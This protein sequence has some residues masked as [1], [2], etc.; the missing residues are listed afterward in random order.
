MDDYAGGAHLATGTDE[1]SAEERRAVSCM[2]SLL[3]QDKVV[4]LTYK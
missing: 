4:I 2:R 1:E 3:N